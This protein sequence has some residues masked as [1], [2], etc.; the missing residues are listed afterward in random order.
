[1]TV[2]FFS[3]VLNH[4]QISLC[5]ELNN[6]TDVDFKFVQMIDL[7]DERKAQGF[8]SYDAPY[9]VYAKKDPEEAHRLCIESDVVIAGVIN[10]DWMN[11]RVSLGKLTFAY[12]ERFLKSAKAVLSPAFWKNGYLNFFKYRNKS[13]EKFK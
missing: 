12:R 9:V 11:E 4:H 5:E 6:A 10:Q 8:K 13:G 7:T 2:A 1:M 3:S